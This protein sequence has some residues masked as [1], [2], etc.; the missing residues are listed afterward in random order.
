VADEARIGL[1]I[2]LIVIGG[3]YPLFAAYR[4]NRRLGRPEGPSTA[5]LIWWLAFT[6][7]FPFA[8]ALTGVGLLV[9]RVGI[10]IAYMA[11]VGGLWGVALI[12]GVIYLWNHLRELRGRHQ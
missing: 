12:A 2:V 1:G 8:L 4:M 7:S 11:I 9:P 6:L 10:Q 5:S 3:M